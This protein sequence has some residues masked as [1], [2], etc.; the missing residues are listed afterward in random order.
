M[1]ELFK[2]YSFA[3]E[4]VIEFSIPLF[5]ICFIGMFIVF[6]QLK[7]YNILSSIVISL[8]ISFLIEILF[9]PI[10]TD[11]GEAYKFSEDIRFMFPFYDP[12]H[13]IMFQPIYSICHLLMFIPLGFI[14][15]H[16]T[17]LLKSFLIGIAIVYGIENIQIYINYIFGYVQYTYDICDILYHIISIFIGIGVY[18]PIMFLK[19]KLVEMTKYKY[20]ESNNI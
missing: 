18:K 12:Y 3:G 16:E 8:Y 13:R 15:R 2:F 20:I 17:N 10:V 1:F 4:G 5:V 14:L 6:F 11:W 7:K 9:F 19:N